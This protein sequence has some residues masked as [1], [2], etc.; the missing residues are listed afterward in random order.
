MAI[1]DQLTQRIIAVIEHTMKMPAGRVQPASTFD[2]LA[3]DSLDGI[4][5]AFA[6]ESEFDV[7]IPDDSLPKMRSVADIVAGIGAL[8]AATAD[9]KPPAPSGAAA[10]PQESPA[11][12][13]FEQGPAGEPPQGDAGETK[14]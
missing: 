5:I 3:I 9:H 10:P 6:L 7:N 13:A 14:D 4:N 11:A 8:L 2:E 1:N 12:A